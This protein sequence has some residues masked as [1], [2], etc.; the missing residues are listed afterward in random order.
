MLGAYS[1]I[2]DQKLWF[3][4][5]QLI[6]AI[7]NFLMLIPVKNILVKHRISQ[8]VFL[9]NVIVALSISIDSIQ[10]G[11]QY[12]QYVWMVAALCSLIALILFSKKKL[13]VRKDNNY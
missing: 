7:F 5:I 6:A 1:L 2:S 11:K 4:I 3:A 9:M 12:I 13:G 10:Q 8:L